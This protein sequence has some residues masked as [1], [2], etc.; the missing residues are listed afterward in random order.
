[1]VQDESLTGQTIS[2]LRAVLRVTVNI[3]ESNCLKHNNVQFIV[4]LYRPVEKGIL[5]PIPIPIS[6]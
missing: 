2:R 6:S 3:Q 5:G 1:M 4:I